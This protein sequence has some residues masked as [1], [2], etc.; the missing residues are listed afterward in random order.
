MKIKMDILERYFTALIIFVLSTVVVIYQSSAR[1]ED[2]PGSHNEFS[3]SIESHDLDVNLDVVNHSIFASDRIEI[4]LPEQD[5]DHFAFMLNHN[6]KIREIR[7][8]GQETLLEWEKEPPDKDV[9]KITAQI[10]ET[11]KDKITVIVKYEGVIY[12]PVITAKELGHLRGD[13]TA[14]LISE[15]GVYLPASAYWYPVRS[16]ELSLFNIKAQIADPYRI[17]TQGELKADQTKDGY[18]VSRWESIIPAD[19]LALVGGRYVTHTKTF[20]NVKVSTYFFEEDDSMS[21]LFLEAAADYIK[22]YSDILG[23]YPYTK[24]DVVENFFSTGYGMPSYTLLGSYVIKRGRGSL[25]PGYLDHEI[26]HSWFGNYVFNDA[27]KGNWVEAL[28]TYCANYYYKELK[29]GEAEAASH[30]EIA[31]LKYSIMVSKDKDYPVHKFVTKTEP[32]DN[33]IGYTKG[34]MVFHQLRQ[35]IGNEQFFNGIRS[36]VKEF[37]GKYAEWEDLQSIFEAASKTDLGWFF[38]Q[39]VDAKGAPELRLEAVSV[40][41]TNKGFLVKGEVAQLGSIYKL[42]IP[43]RI[44]LGGGAKVYN[45]DIDKIRNGFEYE[46]DA[47]PVSVA[48]DPEYHLFR[49]IAAHDIT[50]CLNAFLEDSS[51]EKTFVYPTR[52]S[53]VEKEIYHG[54]IETA[55]QKTGGAITSDTEITQAVLNKSIFLAGNIRDQES[56][57]PLF[58][59]L[60][61]G[62][63]FG[64]DSFTIDGEEYKGAE[65]AL[66]FTYRNPLDMSNFIT[67]YFG[68]SAQAVSRAGYIF[69][70]GWESYVVFKNGLPVKRG[71]FRSRESDTTY[72]LPISLTDPIRSENIMNHIKYLASEGLAGRYPGTEGD[73]LAKDYIKERFRQYKIAPVSIADNEPYEQR[74]EIKITDLTGFQIAFQKVKTGEIIKQRG[75]PFNFSPD[76]GFKSGLFFA[77]YGIS[78]ETYSDYKDVEGEVKGK[79]LIILDG[80]PDIIKDKVGDDIDLLFSKID[81]GQK[82][83]ATAVIIYASSDQIKKYAPYLA[84]PSKIPES[85]DEIIRKK[86]QKGAFSSTEM[87]LAALISRSKKPPKGIA[88]PVV[89]IS[90]EDAGYKTVEKYLKLSKIKK[91]IGQKNRHYSKAI[92]KLRLNMG[93]HHQVKEVRTNNVVGV[94]AGNDAQSKNEVVVLGAHYDHLGMDEKGNIFFGADDNASGIGALLE[95]ARIFYEFRDQI[96]RTV[97]FA[98]FGAEEWG[99]LGSRFFV[100]NPIFQDKKI[101]SMLNIDSVGRGDPSKVWIIGSSIYP[102]LGHIADKYMKEF[103]LQEGDNIDQYAFTQ[104]SD[105]YPFHLKGIPS[106]DFFSTDYK[107]LHKTTDTWDLIDSEK[108]GS[109]SKLV[110]MTLF[111]LAMR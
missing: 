87:E 102:E 89:L 27:A 55:K 24:F 109:V 8:E 76:G 51:N 61:Q 14:G 2:A 64:M 9:Q 47:L 77:G 56:C 101:V 29:R 30:R 62:V 57:K 107:E 40:S 49:R 52:G 70:Y 92:K 95:I 78:H 5:L 103:G 104:G 83:G 99:L 46:V 108:V 67:T 28:T 72:N 50:P 53:D 106:V 4:T 82:M 10:P 94:L 15:E 100:D 48:L 98:A 26:V 23:P 6:L 11:I 97:V 45:L 54:L 111:D 66:L 96:R 19:G 33:E 20:N 18:S 39:W 90:Y 42:N 59:N 74:F 22:L 93:I 81:T 21:D 68:L 16:G 69:F 85:L 110:F 25:E 105:H 17:V 79:A 1:A 60:P 7:I 3:Y 13:V 75:T 80:A 73:T 88:I 35:T 12:D 41:P 65:Y 84:Y 43:I 63:Q 71:S 91:K 36:L 31:S 58:D 37:G 44:D 34:S 38:S 86:R 32:F